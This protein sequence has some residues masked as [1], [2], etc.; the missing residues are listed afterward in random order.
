MA[1]D[2]GL[3]RLAE[4]DFWHGHPYTEASSVRIR[5]A[6][7]NYSPYFLAPPTDE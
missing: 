5:R 4:F 7:M 2:C 3:D 6:V 1:A